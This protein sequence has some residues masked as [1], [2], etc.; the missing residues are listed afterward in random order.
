MRIILVMLLGALLTGCTAPDAPATGTGRLEVHAVAGPV[1]PVEKQPPD[2][3]CA[4][5][6]G[7]GG[8]GRLSPAGGREVL[9]G[10]GVTDA[11][12]VV[13]FDIAG[14]PYLVTGMPVPGLMGGQVE[15]PATVV[16]GRIASVV[17]E[18]DTG[19]R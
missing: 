13:T 7:P 17:L 2:P 14:G 11:R 19:I 3:A 18:Y 15:V 4:A 16:A 12:G 1:C 5:R 9:L 10:R 8:T 6:P